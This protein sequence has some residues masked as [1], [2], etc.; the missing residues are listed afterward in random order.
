MLVGRIEGKGESGKFVIE[1]VVLRQ[2]PDG[3]PQ[4]NGQFQRN[5]DGSPVIEPATGELPMTKGNGIDVTRPEVADVIATATEQGTQ[6]MLRRNQS[7]AAEVNK[8]A[9]D[10]VV[11]STAKPDIKQSLEGLQKSLGRR[12]DALKL[13]PEDR[14][15][16]AAAM[17]K[18]FADPEFRKK[19]PKQQLDKLMEEEVEVKAGEPKRKIGAILS[20]PANGGAAT[21]QAFMDSYTYYSPLVG[22]EINKVPD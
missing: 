21:M 22:A 8:R 15:A 2:G 20:D 7:R 1:G 10:A 9:N 17:T 4:V 19:T 16:I 18:N 13:R 12:L 5:K 14:S 11:L 3:K 6:S